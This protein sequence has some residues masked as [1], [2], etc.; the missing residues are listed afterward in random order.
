MRR[1][2]FITMLSVIACALLVLAFAYVVASAHCDG[3]DGPVVKAAR[4]ALRTGNVNLVLI[5]VG[6]GDEAEVREAFR[7]TAVVRRQSPQARE[8]ADRYFFE[9]LVRLHRAGEGEPF[10]GLKPAGR[11]LGPV[12]PAA[13]R[14]IETGSAEALLKLF[15]GD[16]RAEVESLFREA[17]AKKTYAADDVE[18]GRAYVHA[19]IRLMHHAEHLYK[20]PGSAA[21]EAGHVEGLARPDGRR[22]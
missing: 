1:R 15:T 22:P 7:K 10:T 17:L 9:T 20:G 19:Y 4:K 18:A 12:I 14:A 8:L 2:R 21:G 3:M 11:D 13:D 5:W 16:A 6:R